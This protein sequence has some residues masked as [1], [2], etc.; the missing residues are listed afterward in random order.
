VNKATEDALLSAAQR[1][2]YF[3]H[4]L[5]LEDV[6]ELVVDDPR[7]GGS[8]YHHLDRALG[9]MLRHLGTEAKL[10]FY[11]MVTTGMA[12]QEA[13]ERAKSIEADRLAVD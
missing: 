12:P 9:R 3:M 6:R 5:N 11:E 7:N 8:A 1:L 4:E 2:S 10:E 13:L